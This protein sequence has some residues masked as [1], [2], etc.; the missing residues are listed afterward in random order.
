M[1]DV[2]LN[3]MNALKLKF[4]KR[5]GYSDHTPGIEVAIA[6][7]ALGACVI[8]KHMTL[9]KTMPGPDLKASLEP[10]SDTGGNRINEMIDAYASRNPDMSAVFPSLGSLNY[11]SLMNCCQAVIG[12]SSSGILEA[13]FFKVPSVNIGNRQAGRIAPASVISCGYSVNEIVTAIQKALSFERYQ[14]EAPNPYEGMETSKQI[15]SVIKQTFKKGIQL[16]KHFY[17]VEWRL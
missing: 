2:N 5:V 15:V 16:E 3:A 7:T 12:N 1:E 13:P 10:D 6:A 9:D 17:D 4:H 8:E 11:L 14:E